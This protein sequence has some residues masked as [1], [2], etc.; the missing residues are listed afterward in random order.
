MAQNAIVALRNRVGQECQE[1]R[2]KSLVNLLCNP[3]IDKTSVLEEYFTRGNYHRTVGHFE[4]ARLGAIQKVHD[5]ENLLL[6][7][8]Q[9]GAFDAWTINTDM[10]LRVLGMIRLMLDLRQGLVAGD[11]VEHDA[12]SP[13][14]E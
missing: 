13:F 9:G 4:A 8:G 12:L 14:I 10:C 3:R 6:Q 1:R 7:C 2:L 11:E 5:L